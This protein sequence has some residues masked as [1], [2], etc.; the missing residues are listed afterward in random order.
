M[1]VVIQWFGQKLSS[2]RLPLR[3]ASADV[4]HSQVQ[5]AANNVQ[6]ARGFKDHLGLIGRRAASRVEHDP[7]VGQPDVTGIFWLYHFFAQDGYIELPGFR[8]VLYGQKVCDEEAVLG[9][10]GV[11]YVMSSPQTQVH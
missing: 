11:G 2:L 7:G 1:A 10:W 8:L 3:I 4:G 5:E 9:Y 6:F